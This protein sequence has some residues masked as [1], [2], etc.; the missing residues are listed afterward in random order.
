MYASHSGNFSPD[1]EIEVF[2]YEHETFSDFY[3]FLIINFNDKFAILTLN[4]YAGVPGT[5]AH[6]FLV[7][8]MTKPC[9]E[10]FVSHVIPSG[11]EH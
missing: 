8:I 4:Y 1:F 5:H 7:Y 11:E 6:L 3:F 9:L 10:I 2:Q